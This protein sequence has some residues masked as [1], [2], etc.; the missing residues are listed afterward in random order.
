MRLSDDGKGKQGEKWKKATMRLGAEGSLIG[1]K[2]LKVVLSK[3]W[4]GAGTS[5]CGIADRFGASRGE[6][7]MRG[8]HGPCAAPFRYE[9]V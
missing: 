9:G 4:M 2:L 1:A 5:V 8:H 7:R 6:W 3:S